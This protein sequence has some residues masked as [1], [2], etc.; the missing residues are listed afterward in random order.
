M[1]QTAVFYKK[2]AEKY[3]VFSAK[4]LKTMPPDPYTIREE[5]GVRINKGLAEKWDQ[6][7]DSL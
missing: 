1:R 7:Y 6:L 5:D 3:I 2:H 4:T